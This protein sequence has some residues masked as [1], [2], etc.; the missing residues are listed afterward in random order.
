M[1]DRLCFLLVS[2][3]L[4]IA[5]TGLPALADSTVQQDDLGRA[6]RQPD[7]PAP[8]RIVSLLPSLTESV[9]ALG[10]CQRLVGVDRYSSWPP[11]FIR[12]L[13]VMGGGIDPNIEAIVAAK[14][15]VV[16]LSRGVALRPRLEA[17]GLRT[18]VLD[19]DS[20]ADMQTMLRRVEYLLGLEATQ[21]AQAVLA[22]I[23]A[24]LA[25][26]AA[27][28]PPA[29]HGKSVYFEAS[30]GGYTAGPES[31]IG[32][33][34]EQ[35]GLKNIVPAGMGP[36]PRLNPELVLRQRPNLLLMSAHSEL[37]RLPGWHQLPA[38]QQQQWCR[39]QPEEID[40]LVRPGPRMD[41][42]AR[43]LG[44]CLRELAVQAT[45]KAER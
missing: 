27:T 26:Q 12:A 25:A 21:P 33:L 7:Q 40:V 34:L 17:L 45:S 28:L 9:C 23:N 36:F 42:A 15:D 3:L 1:V 19:A 37:P 22:R 29:M 41:E 43:V 10:A 14:P 31:F 8:Q 44:D 4:C 38:V 39:F 13:P 6:L 35:L 16:L 30:S 2:C 5:A 11:E 18:V 24:A 20:F 32:H